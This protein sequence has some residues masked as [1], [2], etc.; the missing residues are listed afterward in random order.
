[1]DLHLRATLIYFLLSMCGAIS[2]ATSGTSDGTTSLPVSVAN[3]STVGTT[4]AVASQSTTNL[5]AS[6]INQ[7]NHGTVNNTSTPVNTNFFDN[8]QKFLQNSQ[9]ANLIQKQIGDFIKSNNVSFPISIMTPENLQKVLQLLG[10]GSG[11]TNLQGLSQYAGLLGNISNEIRNVTEELEQNIGPQC[12]SH[13]Q[14]LVSELMKREQWAIKMID[15][16]GKIPSG[17]LEGNMVWP[18]SYDECLNVN[19]DGKFDGQY[20]TAT[21]SLASILGS[22]FP[23]AAGLDLRMGVCMP[24]SCTAPET[25]TVL[26]TLFG[27]L[28]L[29]ENKLQ[30]SKI[31][32]S[33][34]AEYD[35]LAIGGLTMC[36]VFVV[37]MTLSTL[38]DVMYNQHQ[39]K[40]NETAPQENGVSP[41]SKYQVN[42]DVKP[43]KPKQPGMM[44]CWNEALTSLRIFE[45]DKMY[46]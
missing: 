41:E 9:V 16:S 2:V 14:F 7:I 39:N 44:F 35:D 22:I 38:F 13:L 6:G 25:K 3:K 23:M 36:G 11:S 40:P 26:N 27:L 15:A 28:P 29:G 20:C 32:C 18:G 31:Q 24:D 34:R 21:L 42:G 33:E 19:V 43:T 8:I 5:S 37:L 30:A 17:L 10:P 4:V 46:F 12:Y 1:M 45:I